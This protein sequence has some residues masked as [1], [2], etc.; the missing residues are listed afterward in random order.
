MEELHNPP[1]IAW[2]QE[3]RDKAVVDRAKYG[4][5]EWDS[6]APQ[7]HLAIVIPNTLESWME[8]KHDDEFSYDY[9]VKHYPNLMAETQEIIDAFRL[10]STT[11]FGWILGSGAAQT[12]KRAAVPKAWELLA[13]NY[14]LYFAE[15]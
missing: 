3:F 7:Q 10:Y 6:Y 5:S 14:D 2:T 4:A 1:I 15:Y 13:K 11:E 9:L 8:T 12:D